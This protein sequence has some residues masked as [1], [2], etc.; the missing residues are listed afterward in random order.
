MGRNVSVG[1]NDQPQMLMGTTAERPAS[2]NSG[3]LYYNLDTNTLQIYNGTG[4]IPVGG[5]NRVV[6]SSSTAVESGN[7][8]WVDTS[9]GPVTLTLPASPTTGDRVQFFDLKG[10]FG[11]NTLTVA[12]NGNPIMRVSDTMT[13]T[14]P[15]AGLTLVFS[16]GTEGWLVEN[17]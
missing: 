1:V 2:V 16:T 9:A 17:I 15:G 13:V 14:T 6:V 11:S 5:Y 8:Y 3:V 7:S 4:W 12:N 10:T